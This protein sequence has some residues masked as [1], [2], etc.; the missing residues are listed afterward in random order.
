MGLG[1]GIGNISAID[2]FPLQ[3]GVFL[4]YF[5]AWEG[6]CEKLTIVSPFK[7]L[8]LDVFLGLGRGLGKNWP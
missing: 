3:S 1:T 4:W 7:A 6:S 8:I 2:S 5:W